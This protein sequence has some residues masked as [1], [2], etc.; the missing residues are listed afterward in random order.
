[1]LKFGLSV[2]YSLS[3]VYILT[4]ALFNSLVE[5]AWLKTVL[6]GILWVFTIQKF[7]SFILYLVGWLFVGRYLFVIC[8]G[9]GALR[10]ELSKKGKN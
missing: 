7:L 6:S 10:W 3:L 5:V 2:L 4:V 8:L 9:L 1:L